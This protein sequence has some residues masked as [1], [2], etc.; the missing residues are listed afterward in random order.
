MKQTIL[1]FLTKEFVFSCFLAGEK[2]KSKWLRE[3]TYWI[4]KLIFESIVFMKPVSINSNKT[5]TRF[6]QDSVIPMLID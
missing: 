2:P 4:Y 3:E 1:C 5:Q 6:K